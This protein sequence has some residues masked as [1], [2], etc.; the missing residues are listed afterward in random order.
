MQPNPTHAANASIQASAELET[1]TRAHVVF[2][3][4]SGA[5]QKELVPPRVCKGGHQE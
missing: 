5:P 4:V 1:R 2:I 3:S